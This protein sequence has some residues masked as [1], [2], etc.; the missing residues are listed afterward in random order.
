MSNARIDAYV[1][2]CS[3]ERAAR[4][5]GCEPRDDSP[6]GW[7]RTT[8]RMLDLPRD[9]RR[10][11]VDQ[12]AWAIPCDEAL[13]VIAAH[14]PIVEMGAGLG[15]WAHL[16]RDRGVEVSAFDKF[17][18]AEQT[19]AAP[20]PWT[21]V[22]R[23]EPRTLRDYAEHALLLCWPPYAES[24]ASDCLDHWRGQTLIYVGEGPSGCTGD[25]LF[26]ERLAAEFEQIAEVNIPQWPGFHDELMVWRRQSPRQK[27]EDT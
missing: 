14:A 26:H 21:E 7:H 12:Y 24:M 15:Y 23:G 1:N 19:K 16:L 17:P 10:R 8:H 18:P 25:D 11:L 13:T 5:L 27:T 20:V 22:H 6:G 3:Y 2:M 4:Q 9:A